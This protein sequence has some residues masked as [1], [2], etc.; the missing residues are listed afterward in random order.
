MKYEIQSE[1]YDKGNRDFAIIYINNKV[2]EDIEHWAAVKQYFLKSYKISDAERI[3]DI[4]DSK[5]KNIKLSSYAMASKKDNKIVILY[6]SI[7]NIDIA[8]LYKK[9]KRKYP[10]HE[11][12]FNS[13]W[14]KA[15]EL[16]EM[17]G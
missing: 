11:I 6:D 1:Y 15:A 7:E 2:V 14:Y 4:M 3:D 16:K 13:Q 8:D 12:S 17:I 9:L 10:N 5:D